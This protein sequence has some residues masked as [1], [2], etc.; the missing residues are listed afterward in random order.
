MKPPSAHRIDVASVVEGSGPASSP[1]P[2]LVEAVRHNSPYRTVAGLGRYHNKIGN[3]ITFERELLLALTRDAQILSPRQSA[4][5]R[6]ALALG[7]M[8]LFQTPDG[9][10]VDVSGPLG[11]FRQ[12]LQDNLSRAIDPDNDSVDGAALRSM[13]PTLAARV[14]AARDLLLNTFVHDFGA[15]HLDAE[16]RHKQLVLVLG[17][18]GGSGFVHLATFG[19]IEELGLTPKLI[20]GSSMGSLLGL[21][22]SMRLGYDHEATLLAVPRSFD[23]AA[24]LST[25][26]GNTR[27]GF[28]GLFH[29]QL[30]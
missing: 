22:R 16:L 3:L 17:G 19:M 21:F 27:F 18:G 9:R 26:T 14:Q 25:F 28:P 15:E 24:V 30:L 1:R 11:P 2:N 7:R 23:L 5:L 6:W 12:W 10:D 20:V 8:M 4:L 29:M 13:C